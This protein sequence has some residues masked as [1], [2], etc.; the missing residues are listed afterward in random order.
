MIA[1]GSKFMSRDA[2]ITWIGWSRGAGNRADFKPI[3]RPF[4]ERFEA[5]IQAMC[6]ISSCQA[7]DFW[8]PDPRS[9]GSP[10]PPSTQP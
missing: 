3:S 4:A 1:L 7:V 8:E 2:Q 6:A 9:H 5:Y 10:M